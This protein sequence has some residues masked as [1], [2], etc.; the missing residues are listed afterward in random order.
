MQSH[1]KIAK[2]GFLALTRIIYVFY[3]KKLNRKVVDLK[4]IQLFS[5][6]I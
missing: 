6:N 3:K 5:V 1:P 4:E 2:N